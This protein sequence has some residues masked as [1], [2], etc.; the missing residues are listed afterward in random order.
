[1]DGGGWWTIYRRV[2]VPLSGPTFAT[3]ALL[4]FLPAWNSY[5]WP[6]MAV[7][8]E[9]LRPVLVGVLYFFQLEVAWGRIMAYMA[10]ITVPVLILFVMFQ[11]AFTASIASTGLKG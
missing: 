2:V 9:D 11:R 5:L 1:M 7:Q 3:V 4:T 10:M 8:Q 6:L